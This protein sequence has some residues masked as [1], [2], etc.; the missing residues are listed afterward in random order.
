MSKLGLWLAGGPLHSMRF[1]GTL[2]TSCALRVLQLNKCCRARWGCAWLKHL[3]RDWIGVHDDKWA[4]SW[5]QLDMTT[6]K[7]V[8]HEEGVQQSTIALA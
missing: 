2:S 8:Q 1:Y 6:N 4:S 7:L 3:S 5:S